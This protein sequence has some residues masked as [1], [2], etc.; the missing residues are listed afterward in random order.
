MRRRIRAGRVG[1]ARGAA[2]PSSDGLELRIERGEQAVDL[3]GRHRRAEHVALR[4]RAALRPQPLEL[5][6]IGY[7]LASHSG[8]NIPWIQDRLR[9]NSFCPSSRNLA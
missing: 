6:A 2:P 5:V 8:S 7:S 9:K 4:L 1:A 3:A